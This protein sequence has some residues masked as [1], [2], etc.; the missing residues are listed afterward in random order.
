MHAFVPAILLRLAGF[1]ELGQDADRDPAD[2]ELREPGDG[3]RGKGVAV[4]G[5]DPL[6]QTVLL[7]EPAEAAQSSLEIEAQHSLAGEQE[8]GVAVLHS[9]GEAEACDPRSGTRP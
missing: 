3:A 1:D 8:A 7:E 6:R 4:V 9:E 5:A 2:R